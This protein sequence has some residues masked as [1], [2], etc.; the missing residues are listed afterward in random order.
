[1]YQQQ[2]KML[3][4]SENDDATSLAS[5][6]AMHLLRYINAAQTG[7]DHLAIL[8]L[9]TYPNFPMKWSSKFVPEQMFYGGTTICQCAIVIILLLLLLLL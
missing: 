7:D 4:S 3:Q 8:I 1:M 2:Q 9:G 5:S 6:N